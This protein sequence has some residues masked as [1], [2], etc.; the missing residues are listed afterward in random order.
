FTTLSNE[1]VKNYKNDKNYLVRKTASTFY[2]E[3]NR[4][5]SDKTLAKAFQNKKIRQ[6]LS[7]AINRK[8]YV[9]NTLGNG[10]TVSKG[11]VSED[12]AK[13]PT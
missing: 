6:A 11:Y 12:L 5:D 7:L 13:N 3:F 9:N 1:Q 8:S 10:S 2:V 4:K